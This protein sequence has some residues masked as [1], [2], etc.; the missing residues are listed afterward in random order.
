MLC[1][2]VL[3]LCRILRRVYL[4]LAAPDHT[5]SY[6]AAAKELIDELR[7]EIKA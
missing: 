6:P 2:A 4:L 7:A 5:A 3:Q 1:R